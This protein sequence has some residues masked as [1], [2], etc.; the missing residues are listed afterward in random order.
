MARLTASG[1]AGVKDNVAEKDEDG[2]AGEL[3]PLLQAILRHSK[4]D[5]KQAKLQI[6]LEELEARERARQPSQQPLAQ[7]THPQP[8]GTRVG[9]MMRVRT[10]LDFS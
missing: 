3:P 7:P 5:G 2:S 9:K 4:H 1:P 6:Q 8:A 10:I